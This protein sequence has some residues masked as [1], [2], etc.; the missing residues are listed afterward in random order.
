MPIPIQQLI[1]KSPLVVS[2]MVVVPI[3]FIYGFYPELLFD[4]NLK[5]VDEHNI[6]KATMGM[7]LSFSLLWVFGIFKTNY[8]K[9]ALLSNIIF[10]LGLGFGRFFSLF[11]DGIPTLLFILGTVGELFL[12]FYGVWIMSRYK[13]KP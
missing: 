1:S 9:P 7:Y 10:M 2:I 11:T 4:I 8:F 5:S 6:F 3:A 13:K 12:G